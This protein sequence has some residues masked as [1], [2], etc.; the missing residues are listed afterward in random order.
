MVKKCLN[1]NYEPPKIPKDLEKTIYCSLCNEDIKL[2]D[3][4]EHKKKEQHI[5]KYDILKKIKELKTNDNDGKTTIIKISKLLTP[6]YKSS[7][8]TNTVE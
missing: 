8:N 4:K 1:C 5:F 6:K 2:K 3:M 7:D